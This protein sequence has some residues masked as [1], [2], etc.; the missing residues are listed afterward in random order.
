MN[1]MR[2]CIVADDID[3]HVGW[4][5][6]LHSI[7]AELARQG[8]PV[9]YCVERGVPGPTMDLVSFQVFSLARIGQFLKTIRALRRAF[10][11]ADLIHVFDATPYG[12]LS[13]IANMGLGKPLIIYSFGSYSLFHPGAR[14]KNW[15]MAWVYKRATRVIIVSDFVRR[16]IEQYGFRLNNPSLMPMGVDTSFFTP[17]PS[18]SVH[19]PSAIHSPYILTAG[20]LKPRKGYHISIPAFAA[21]AHEFPELSYVIVGKIA[22][23]DAYVTQLKEIAARCGVADRI[24]WLHDITDE[25]LR[26]LYRGAEAFALCALTS[27]DAIEGFGMVYIE[28][29]ACGVPV[30]GPRGT[31]AEAAIVHGQTGLLTEPSVDGI[32]EAMRTILRDRAAAQ[33]MGAAG[34]AHVQ[35]FDWQRIGQEWVQ[36]YRSLISP[37][38]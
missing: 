32:A 15:L 27:A 3:P 30:I 37:S 31:G 22:V 7:S 20:G 38:V 6:A 23:G 4:G 26:E 33:R 36:I 9:H 34:I 13:C 29:S 24:Q 10:R 11:R 21:I 18:G 28:A 14:I 35:Q 12:I 19:L 1:T 5:R 16:Q 17:A 25:E 2:V 8:I